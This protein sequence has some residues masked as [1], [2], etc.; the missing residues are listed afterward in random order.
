MSILYGSSKP[1][2]HSLLMVLGI[3]TVTSLLVVSCG[4]GGSSGNGN[5]NGGN[6]GNIIIDNDNNPID[7]GPK[8]CDVKNASEDCD[9]DMVNNADDVDDDNDGLIEIYDAAMLWAMHCNPDGTSYTAPM[10]TAEGDIVLSGGYPVCGTEASEDGALATKAPM[11]TTECTTE[12]APD[13]GIYLCGYELGASFAFPADWISLR[14]RD[15]GTPDKGSFGAIFEGNGYEL[16]ALDYESDSANP[17]GGLF[18]SIERNAT[19]SNTIIRNLRVVGQLS[20]AASVPSVGGIAGVV[21]GATMVAIS[22][23][24]SVSRRTLDKISTIGGLVGGTNGSDDIYNSFS[25]G[26]VMVSDVDGGEGS[27]VLT[28]VGGLVGFVVDS[29]AEVVSSY[30]SGAVTGRSA[31]DIIGGVIGSN[32]E[33]SVL[34]RS[35]SSA[36]VN[37]GGGTNFGGGLIGYEQAPLGVGSTNNYYNT[38]LLTFT[39]S[40]TR[41]ATGTAVSADQLTGCGRD[42]KPLNGPTTECTVTMGSETISLFAGWSSAI[43][44]FGTSRQLP[45]LKYALIGRAD[46]AECSRTAGVT[47]ADLPFRPN[48][49]AQP[50]CGKL[51]P[52][53]GRQI[54]AGPQ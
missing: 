36:T 14:D 9:N 2:L 29:S 33:S 19:Q 23:A 34:R 12:T 48:D 32:N 26:T 13:S 50:Y 43:W 17:V 22:S 41:N 37:G 51:L 18:D 24:A 16:N 7:D 44:D 46:G 27:S 20:A 5:V 47:V 6:G 52:G 3:L 31:M 4:S 28:H 45:A 38:D 21:T 8:A 25:T 42:G 1:T 15:I 35:Y 53:Q 40:T 30:A 11:D 49:I 39:S 10:T 54:G